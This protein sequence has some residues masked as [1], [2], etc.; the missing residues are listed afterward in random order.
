MV[1]ASGGP[2]AGRM[3]TKTI[4]LL[5]ALLAAVLLLVT[6]LGAQAAKLITGKQVKD[7]SLTGKD[8]KDDSL[9]GKDV[10]E[11]TL[12]TVPSAKMATT[13]GT[14]DS[15]ATAQALATLGPGETQSGAFGASTGSVAGMAAGYLGFAIT[16][17]R[18]LPVAIAEENVIDT[19][20]NPD[21][22]NCAGPGQAAPGYL[23]LYFNY[24]SDI[25]YVYAYSTVAPYSTMTPSVGLG[26][27]A[28]VTGEEAYVDGIWTVTAPEAS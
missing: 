2:D 16:Y 20:T 25:D 27:Y 5:A 8:V 22:V 24:H 19:E 7:S 9:T 23:C 11:K 17:P 15:A 14:A 3:R 10:A 26:L 21:P 4:A 18:S 6:P 12:G 28:Q 1:V 13:A